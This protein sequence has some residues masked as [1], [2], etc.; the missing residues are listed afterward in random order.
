V[1]GDGKP[2][3]DDEEEDE[4]LRPTEVE[5]VIGERGPTKFDFDIEIVIGEVADLA[6]VLEFK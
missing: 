1:F 2:V 3:K 5:I 4:P 6:D